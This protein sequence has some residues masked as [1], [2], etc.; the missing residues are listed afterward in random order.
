MAHQRRRRFLAVNVPNRKYITNLPVGAI[1]EV[2]GVTTRQG[3][4]GVRAGELPTG[5]AA[6]C[7]TQIA[8]RELTARAAVERSRSAA[9][10]ALLLDPVVPD[11]G[12]AEKLLAR[13]LKANA[14]YLPPLKG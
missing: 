9:L 2:P 6:L 14:R 11:I 4:Q 7:R 3:V 8:I 5:I 10:Q 1:V 13:L 12:T